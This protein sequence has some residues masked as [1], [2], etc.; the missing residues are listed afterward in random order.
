[1]K[2][3][4]CDHTASSRSSASSVERSRSLCLI[5]PRALTPLKIRYPY[6]GV[7]SVQHEVCFA[8]DSAF[9]W[10][11]PRNRRWGKNSSACWPVNTEQI[12]KLFLPY[13]SSEADLIFVSDAFDQSLFG[14][15]SIPSKMSLSNSAR[16][17]SWLLD[18]RC[19]AH[20]CLGSL[21]APQF[22]LTAAQCVSKR[23]RYLWQKR[24]SSVHYR[25]WRIYAQIRIVWRLSFH[26][27]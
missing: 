7:E 18:I 13:S 15:E 3:C 8:G 24:M 19:C 2:V 12:Q 25:F 14:R 6:P 27:K 9:H 17:L 16:I 10:R 22:A 23:E 26:W 5:Y 1:M 21:I 11:S 4:C 20:T